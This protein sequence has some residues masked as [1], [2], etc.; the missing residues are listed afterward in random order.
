[1]NKIKVVIEIDLDRTFEDN[2]G[3]QPYSDKRIYPCHFV[4]EGKVY[5]LELLNRGTVIST[6]IGHV[7][8]SQKAGE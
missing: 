7:L 4:S 3:P 6:L 1:M 2:G 8:E 5:E